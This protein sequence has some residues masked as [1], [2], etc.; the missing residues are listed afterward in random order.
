[1]EAIGEMSKEVVLDKTR[2]GKYYRTTVPDGVR[3][4]LE[5]G[6]GDAV[7]W[8]FNEGKITIRKASR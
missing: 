7:E 2:I 6:E 5:V 1:M 3:K 4:F 8:V